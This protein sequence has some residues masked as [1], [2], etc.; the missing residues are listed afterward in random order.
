LHRAEDSPE[1]RRNLTPVTSPPEIRR[2]IASDAPKIADLLGELGYAAHPSFILERLTLLRGRPDA[3][4]LVAEAAETVIGVVAVHLFPL[5]HADVWTGRITALVVSAHQRRRGIGRLLLDAAEEFAW[6]ARCTRVEVT[7]GGT[8]EPAPQFY[9]SNG[10]ER[11]DQ[12]L[13]KM[14][15]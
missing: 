1:R 5:F 9:E 2:A 15:P 13:V 11:L 8:H 6:N 14:R 4:V 3:C 7:S 10:Y 12:H